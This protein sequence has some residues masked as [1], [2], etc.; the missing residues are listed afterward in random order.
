MRHLIFAA[1]LAAPVVVPAQIVPGRDLLE[2]PVGTVAEAPAL[3][4]Q[5]G[6]GLWNPALIALPTSKLLRIGA[7]ALVTP[8]EQGVSSHLLS[9]A[10]GLAD[11]TTVAISVV[12]ASV[13]DLVATESDPQSVGAELQYNTLVASIT[14]ARRQHKHVVLG[15][16]IRYRNG[17]LDGRH[18]SSLGIDGGLLADGLTQF[19]IRVGLSTFLWQP[20]NADNERTRYSAAADARVLGTNERREARVGYG[21]AYTEGLTRE[22]YGFLAGRQGVLEGRVG[23]ARMDAYGRNSTRMRLGLGLHYARYIIGIGRDENGAGLEPIY[24][25]TLSALIPRT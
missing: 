25:F 20:A 23:L 1:L 8:S 2:F 24:Q 7:A 4:L 15:A 9:V 19:D 14:A 21:F 10:L 12:R 13:T 18:A 16:A 22:H 3:A 6:D 11:Q 5:T 17:E